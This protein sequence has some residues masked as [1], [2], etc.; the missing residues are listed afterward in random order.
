MAAAVGVIRLGW[1]TPSPARDGGKLPTDLSVGMVVEIDPS[2]GRDERRR[3]QAQTSSIIPNPRSV[4]AHGPL[5][6]KL[7]GEWLDFGRLRGAFRLSQSDIERVEAI[8]TAAVRFLTVENETSFHE[9]AKLR[10]GVLLIQTS[11]PGSA[12]LALLRRLP[13][14]L[15]FHHFGDSDEAGFAILRDLR[16]RSG[17]DFQA[18]HMERGRPNFEQESLGRPKPDWPFY[19]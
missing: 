5:P 9:L 10:P 17:R 16:E 13:A 3:R 8:H 2:P 6:L 4:L 11:F 12:T 14:T 1:F 18:L 7:D 19:S 15:E